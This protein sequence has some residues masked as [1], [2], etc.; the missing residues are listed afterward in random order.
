MLAAIALLAIGACAAPGRGCQTLIDYVDFVRAGGLMYIAVGDPRRQL[1]DAELGPEQF[2]VRR[3]LA[4]SCNP[5]DYQPADGDAAFL[6]TGTPVYAVRGYASTFRLAAHR[7]DGRLVLYEVDDNPKARIGRD[8]LDIANKV[9]AITLNSKVDGRTVLGTIDDPYRVDSLVRLVLDAPIDRQRHGQLTGFVSFRLRDGTATTQAYF[10][11][12]PVLGRGILIPS[13]FAAAMD[14]LLANAPTPTPVPATINLS[15]RYGLAQA[16]TIT[17]K[18]PRP[19]PPGGVIQD[20][21]RVQQFVASLD[22]DLAAM[23]APTTPADGVVVI[24]GF[25][26]HW[27]SL[28]YDSAADRLTVAQPQDH[29]AVRPSPQFRDLLRQAP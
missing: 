21:N 11:D 12:V 4:D 25:S 9:I 16:T 7:R 29:L 8:L 27:V 17:I 24:F 2:R 26:D 3:T 23:P 28:V 19:P 18:R 22:A 10:G 14:R 6:L 13:A 15:Q 20:P 5:P 1:T